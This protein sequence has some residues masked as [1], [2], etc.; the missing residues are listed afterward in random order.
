MFAIRSR[1]GSATSDQAH[2]HEIHQPRRAA[3]DP[4][5]GSAY[6]WIYGDTMSTAKHLWEASHSYYCSESNYFSNE[7]NFQFKSWQD[8]LEEMGGSDFDYNLV[9]RWDWKERNDKG[10][11]NF[12]GDVN[13]RNGNLQLFFMQQ[14]KGKF[15]CCEVEVCRADEPAVIAFLAPR[16]AYLRDLWTPISDVEQKT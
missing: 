14:R 8:F 13:Y 1:I 16:W 9:F 7:C 4:D 5:P 3:A 6:S 11:P 12:T 15:V 10:E 2:P